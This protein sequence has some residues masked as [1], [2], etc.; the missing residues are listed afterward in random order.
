MT[1]L[2]AFIE[3]IGLLGPGLNQWPHAAALLTGQAPYAPERT[4]LP[5]PAGLPAAERRRTGP[6]VRV[7]LA[8]GLE[9]VAA[10]GRDAATLATVFAASGG[11]SQNCHAICETLAGEDRQLSPTRFHNSVHNAPAGYWSIATRAMAPS[12]VLCAYDGSF[13]A[14]LLESLC[15]VTVDAVPT[16]LI[17]FDT[18]YPEPLRAVRPIPDAFGVA[19]VLAP[20]AGPHTLA[21]IDA[22]LT[23]APATTLASPEFEPLRAGNPAAR[24]LPL[25]EAL[26]ARRPASVVLD[27]LPDTR[28]HVDIVMPTASGAFPR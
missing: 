19:L 5:P 22:R 23:D 16:L 12:N 4:A 28:L 17:A 10:S 20:E 13:V 2:S 15:Q 7:A 9:A 21:R 8:V 27:Y 24:A 18:D 14:G 1:R 6:A 25:L 26:A 11:D 3:G